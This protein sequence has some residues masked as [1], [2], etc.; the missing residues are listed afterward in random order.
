VQIDPQGFDGREH[1][2]K[3]QAMP[4]SAR[5]Q[6]QELARLVKDSVDLAPNSHSY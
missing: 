4:E 6:L 2:F 3:F 1:P 5:K